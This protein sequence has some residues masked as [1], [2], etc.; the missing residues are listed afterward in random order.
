MEEE[1][2]QV[3]DSPA[4]EPS[5]DQEEN[6]AGIGGVSTVSIARVSSHQH[7]VPKRENR[8]D[9]KRHVEA[10][11][12]PARCPERD[13][14]RDGHAPSHVFRV[15]VAKH[16][17]HGLCNIW[18]YNHGRQNRKNGGNKRVGSVFHFLSERQSDGNPTSGRKGK[19]WG[20]ISARFAVRESGSIREEGKEP[21]R[22]TT[23]NETRSHRDDYVG[24]R[25]SE[26]K[27]GDRSP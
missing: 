18:C 3:D 19:F 25:S 20:E 7:C 9:Y 16:I 17:P 10:A 13:Q 15:T 24:Y 1:H 8:G 22:Q 5:R 12:H 6:R 4:R 2:Q 26:T 23:H 27:N 11:S 14:C 21:S